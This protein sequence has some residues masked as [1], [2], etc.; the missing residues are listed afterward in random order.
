MRNSSILKR[1][2][3]FTLVELLVVIAIIAV[4]I[5][6]LLPAV[7]KVR[8]AAQRAQ[9]QNNIKQV[10]L[11]TQ[12]YHDINQHFPNNFTFKA[13]GYTSPFIALLPFLEQQPL[14]QA[15]YN[16][17]AAPHPIGTNG[18]PLGNSGTG[19][20]D[21]GSSALCASTL[22][23]L[24]CPSDALPAP[25]VN[26]IPGTNIFLGMTS[27][28]VNSSIFTDEAAELPI[29]SITDGLSNTL[30][31]SEV[32][33]N[34]PNWGVWQKSGLYYAPV[35]SSP[36]W[37]HI[38]G[39]WT[40]NLGSV[41]AGNGF[42]GNNTLINY[43]MPAEPIAVDLSGGSAIAV[44]SPIYGARI[45]ALGSGHPGGVN[46]AFADASVHFLSNSINNTPTL[47][48]ALCTIAGGEVIDVSGF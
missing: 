4:L 28:R 42:S 35:S 41:S 5:G 19:L 32:Y 44:E 37:T 30:L 3:G 26:Q 14:Y 23:V 8:E 6:L 25:A 13:F 20:T 33:S 39:F 12:S 11:A 45:T 46:C 9:C 31:L 22:S 48:P 2:S 43:L 40:Y 15:F 1:R 34:D 16:Q 27:Y 7:Q 18:G 17:A 10:A 47:L 21:G 24:V 29:A 36:Y 38:N